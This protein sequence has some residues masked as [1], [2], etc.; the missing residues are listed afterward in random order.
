MTFRCCA[1][2][3]AASLLLAGL[4]AC[5]GSAQ[6]RTT[7][8]TG[9][10][11]DLAFTLTSETGATV[12][13]DDF[14]GKVKV[15][16]FG[17]TH[18][19]D[20]CPITLGHLAAALRTMGAD[21]KQ[22]RVLFVSVDP[23]RDTP[24]LLEKYTD[25]FGPQFVGLTGTQEQLRELTKRYRVAYSYGPPDENGNYLVNHGSAIFVFDRQG[26]VRLL[27]N[28]SD[29]TKAIAHDLELLVNE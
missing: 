2:L 12:H 16:F 8:I 17:Y 25:A 28:R 4:A 24:A 22:V 7:D 18:C 3:V 29:P 21:A 26:H 5:S 9:V 13:A 27:M 6:W 10:M 20:I 11:P 1:S 15:L 19:P 23:K 14:R